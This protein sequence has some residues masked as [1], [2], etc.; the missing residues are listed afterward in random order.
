MKNGSFIRVN[1]TSPNISRRGM[2]GMV[3]DDF[4]D[5]VGLVFYFDRHN[6]PQGCI[7]VGPEL[8]EKTELD[9]SSYD[10]T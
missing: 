2:D 6:R 1:S 3:I 10:E 7:C 8:W 5:Y 4:G 9:L